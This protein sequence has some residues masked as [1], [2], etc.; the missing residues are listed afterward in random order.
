MKFEHATGY[1]TAENLRTHDSRTYEGRTWLASSLAAMTK[2]NT[3]GVV[4]SVPIRGDPA[5]STASRWAQSVN[6]RSRP[7]GVGEQSGSAHQGAVPKP[8]PAPDQRWRPDVLFQNT[9]SPAV[10]KTAQEKGKR[11]FGW[12]SDM[13]AFTVP[14]PTWHRL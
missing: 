6:L 11:A 7:G 8:Q 12:D 13:T 3:L 9:D 2:S 4:G 1:K 14:R 5:T 10:L